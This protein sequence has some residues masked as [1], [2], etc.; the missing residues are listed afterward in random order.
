MFV[1]SMSREKC[2]LSNLQLCKVQEALHC[3]TALLGFDNLT[4][5]SIM[6]LVLSIISHKPSQQREFA[7][8]SLS[9]RYSN[10]HLAE[11]ENSEQQLDGPCGETA[12]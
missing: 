9:C 5:R 2:C 3:L 10:F 4:T 8:F 7:Q 12:V 1:V 11:I 6:Y